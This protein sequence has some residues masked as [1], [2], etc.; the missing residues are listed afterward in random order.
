VEQ[1]RGETAEEVQD[2]LMAEPIA[3]VLCFFSGA[4]DDAVLL[5]AAAHCGA[6]R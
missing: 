1:A 3:P 5:Q 4:W 2:L 6:W